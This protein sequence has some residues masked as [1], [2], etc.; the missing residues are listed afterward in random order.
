MSKE[1]KKLS[2]SLHEAKEAIVDSVRDK[3]HAAASYIHDMKEAVMESVKDN[4]EELKQ[5]T[6]EAQESVCKYVKQNPWKTIGF[7]ALAGAII[8]KLFSRK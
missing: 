6:S 4:A 5:K 2:E 7:S 1:E 3:S 8:A